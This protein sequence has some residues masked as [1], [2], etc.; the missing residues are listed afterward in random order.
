VQIPD[1]TSDVTAHDL[2]SGTMNTFVAPEPATVTI[3]GHDTLFV[4]TSGQ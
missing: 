1:Q 3:T 4:W 2:S